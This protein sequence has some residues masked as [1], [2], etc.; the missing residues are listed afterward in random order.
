[1]T[2]LIVLVFYFIG[3]LLAYGALKDARKRSLNN[4]PVEKWEKRVMIA[5]VSLSWV[6]VI[7]TFIFGGARGF[8]FR[9]S[10]DKKRSQ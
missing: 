7:L 2:L 3:V 8:V 10:K 1:M 5:S 9:S 4:F 6:M